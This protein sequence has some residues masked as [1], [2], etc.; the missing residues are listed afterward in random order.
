[1]NWRS[2]R[3][4]ALLIVFCI[5][6]LAA[7]FISLHLISGTSDT[8]VPPLSTPSSART[9]FTNDRFNYSIRYPTQWYLT[10]TSN[11][12]LVRVFMKHDPS[13]PEA[14]AFEITCSA[15]PNQLDAQTFWKQTQ[16][17]AGGEREIGPI[18]FS[19]GV[20]AYVAK[21]QGQ[22]PY[23]VYTLVN[24]HI[25]CQIVTIQTDLSNTQIVLAVVNSFHW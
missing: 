16:P 10:T 4:L 5:I 3:F 18:T 6:L 24:K 9:I 19:S 13:V 11:T 21:G 8:I 17:P 15:N 22:T 1:M 2:P 7:L 12:S 14:V 23:T 25:A 20:S